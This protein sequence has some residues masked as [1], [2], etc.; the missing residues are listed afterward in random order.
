MVYALADK[1]ADLLAEEF[2]IDRGQTKWTQKNREVKD[3]H[4]QRTLMISDFRMYLELALARTPNARLLFWEKENRKELRDS[5]YIEDRQGRERKRAIA[6]DA[7]F[8][9]KDTKP[10]PTIY[11]F[12][13]ADRSTMAR[14]KRRGPKRRFKN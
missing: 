7:F 1:G 4:I 9:I 6:P 2:G 14:E 11:F 13:E 5:V 8:R 12:L 10:K 3:R